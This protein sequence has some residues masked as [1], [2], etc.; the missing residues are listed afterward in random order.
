MKFARILDGVAVD[1]LDGDPA[2]RFH[3]EI[4]AEFV[5]VPAEVVEGSRLV[6]GAWVAPDPVDPAPAPAD[7][8]QMAI[9]DFLRLFDG[10]E[11]DRFNEREA[12]CNALTSADYQ[13]AREGDQAKMI[14]VGFKRFLSF[15]NALRA[16]LIELNH[17]ETIQG[18][19][20][21]VPLGVLTEPRLQDVLAGRIPG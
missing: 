14:L 11:L 1:V 15:Y 20:L 2:E 16:G 8:G 5:V 9:I 7:L 19:G 10:E 13:A 6:D 21:L 3:P 4:A 18:L 12:E 17:P